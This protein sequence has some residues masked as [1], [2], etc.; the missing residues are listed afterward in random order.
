MSGTWCWR[1]T[2]ERQKGTEEVERWGDGSRNRCSSLFSSGSCFFHPPTRRL[3]RWTM[4]QWGQAELS[5]PVVPS[6]TVWI[7]GIFIHLH[8]SSFSPALCSGLGILWP[9]KGGLCAPC[10][11][12]DNLLFLQK[13]ADQV[14]STT[15]LWFVR[16]CS[17]P[18]GEQNCFD[19]LCGVFS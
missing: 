18:R 12:W 5:A 19:K 7:E 9:F 3:Q 4:V 1:W 13:K 6:M 11:R 17:C 15:L 14:K 16:Y 10:T 2:K 8:E